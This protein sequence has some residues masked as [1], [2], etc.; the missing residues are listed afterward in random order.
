MY[1]KSKRRQKGGFLFSKTKK[2]IK[3]PTLRK[4]KNENTEFTEIITK[5]KSVSDSIINWKQ[6]ETKNSIKKHMDELVKKEED[7]QIRMTIEHIEK[8]T[9]PKLID[10]YDDDV[11]S[12][13][14]LKLQLKSLLQQISATQTV[15]NQIY[16]YENIQME[17]IFWLFYVFIVGTNRKEQIPIPKQ[18]L[19][20]DINKSIVL[21]NNSSKTG[22]NID[23]HLQDYYKSVYKT[24]EA[25]R[26]DHDIMK[27][28]KSFKEV[29]NYFFNFIS[30]ES[31]PERMNNLPYL[32]D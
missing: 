29:L 23:G 32:P 22:G 11:K 2:E 3:Y 31:E 15:E 6:N 25:I 27:T 26:N 9:D 8:G 4:I 14:K 16:I 21:V 7:Y 19:S 20:E 1:V 17:T 24:L 5:I 28:P 12:K 18:L 10:L 30:G 13:V